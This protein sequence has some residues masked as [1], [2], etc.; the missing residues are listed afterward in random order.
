MSSLFSASDLG[1]LLTVAFTVNDELDAILTIALK[2]CQAEGVPVRFVVS[3]VF[4]SWTPASNYPLKKVCRALAPLDQLEALAPLLNHNAQAIRLAVI[5]AYYNFG[6]TADV[7]TL[8]TLLADQD[9]EI[10]IKVRDAIDTIVDPKHTP[11]TRQAI[12]GVL[13]DDDLQ[14]TRIMLGRPLESADIPPVVHLL[15]SPSGPIRQLARKA[16]QS[17]SHRD[18]LI[19]SLERA[20]TSEASISAEAVETLRDHDSD[21]AIALLIR[22]LADSDRRGD[23]PR[24]ALES[25]GAQAAPRLLEAFAIDGNVRRRWGG[26]VARVAGASALPAL[27]AAFESP[28]HAVRRSAA[29][30]LLTLRD[31]ASVTPLISRLERANHDETVEILNVLGGLGS[32]A[33]RQ[34]ILRYAEHQEPHVRIAAIRALQGFNTPEATEMVVK[35]FRAPNWRIRKAVV[36][37][38]GGWDW[39]NREA[40]AVLSDA[41]QDPDTRVSG[42]A[43]SSLNRLA[44]G[45]SSEVAAA[46]SFDRLGHGATLEAHVER[47]AHALEH[48]DANERAWATDEITTLRGLLAF[49]LAQLR[50][51]SPEGERRWHEVTNR[52]KDVVDLSEW[53]LHFRQPGAS[54]SANPT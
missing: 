9:P 43:A 27:L 2:A 5:H 39:Q 28:Y 30:G 15:F 53:T 32:P 31:A 44:H 6:V 18:T 37:V 13:S 36:D 33:A 34:P 50:V 46:S 29:D 47:L 22:I 16:L 21:R 10:R 8:E 17:T 35:A 4:K 49:H 54:S 24:A 48:G 19:D 38:I 45:A 12:V 3:Q 20:I 42:A 7:R 26:L 1:R 52:I 14:M 40:V 25:L 11:R 41:F 51:F 23:G